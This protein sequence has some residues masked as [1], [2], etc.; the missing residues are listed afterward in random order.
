MKTA[1]KTWSNFPEVT[2]TFVK[3][4]ESPSNQDIADAFPLIEHFTALM[5]KQKTNA[6][7]VDKARRKMFVKDGRDFETIPITS[8]ALLEHITSILYWKTRLE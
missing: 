2:Q 1:W 4:R 7:S 3:L 5:Y 8:S 6:L